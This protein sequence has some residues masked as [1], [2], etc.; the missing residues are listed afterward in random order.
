MN[1]DDLRVEFVK[2]SSNSLGLFVNTPA[3]DDD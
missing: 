2:L 1:L 3:G